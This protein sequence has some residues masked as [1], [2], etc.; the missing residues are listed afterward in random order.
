MPTILTGLTDQPAQQSPIKLP[1][2]STATL[3]LFWTPQQNAWF[4]NLSWDGQTPSWQLNGMKLVAGPNVLRQYRNQ[5]PFG[6]T[7][8]TSDQLDPTSQED[9]VD[10]TCTLLLLDADDVHN[11]E[12]AFF[13]G[14]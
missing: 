5:I 1:D 8:S 7:V 4:Y 6:I 14:N 3:N 9:F 13:P 2:G 10:G 11:I 12:G